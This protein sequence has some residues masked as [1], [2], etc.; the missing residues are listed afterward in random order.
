MDDNSLYSKRVY[1]ILFTYYSMNIQ[2]E[3][4]EQK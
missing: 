4:T 3:K 2:R 1:D